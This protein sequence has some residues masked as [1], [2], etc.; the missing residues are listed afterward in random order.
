ML[1]DNP[2]L[3]KLSPP[4]QEKLLFPIRLA[5]LL[6]VAPEEETAVHKAMEA[7]HERLEAEHEKFMYLPNINKRLKQ[8]SESG[9][10]RELCFYL[11]PAAGGISNGEECAITY[12]RLRDIYLQGLSRDDAHIVALYEQEFYDTEDE[13]N[14]SI[15]TPFSGIYSFYAVYRLRSA[16]KALMLDE[17]RAIA[18]FAEIFIGIKSGLNPGRFCFYSLSRPLSDAQRLK[19]ALAD[20]NFENCCSSLVDETVAK[21]LDLNAKGIDAMAIYQLIGEKL[22]KPGRLLIDKDYRIFLP[23]F[24]NAEVP[25]YPSA[26]AVFFLFLRHPEGIS[27]KN[28]PEYKDELLALYSKIDRRMLT[29]ETKDTVARI[30]DCND[31]S[32]NVN[33]SRI[34]TNFLSLF[35][36]EL[37][38]W[39]FIDGPKGGIKTIKLPRELVSWEVPPKLVSY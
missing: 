15:L 8:M 34:K 13:D 30:V 22:S 19:I 37:A 23:D 17:V 24:G 28:L 32:I 14:D 36:Y 3:V 38:S 29:S 27:Y 4:L 12:D 16:N 39:Y 26:K 7:R 33:C 9:R 31:N 25:L 2:N 18:N 5:G 6:Y 21:I 35:H 1:Y 11:N 20:E 10:L